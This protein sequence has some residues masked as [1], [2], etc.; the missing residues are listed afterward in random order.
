[1]RAAAIV[2]PLSMAILAALYLSGAVLGAWWLLPL[3]LNVMLS[4]ALSARAHRSF[5]RATVGQR[6][7]ERYASMFSLVCE[8][9]WSSPLLQRMQAAMRTGDRPP[10]VSATWR[11]WAAG[12]SSAAARHCCTFRCRR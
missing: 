4:Y 10:I 6:A 3:S 1:M 2:L 12:R 8:A 5:D 7:L 9:D 11:R